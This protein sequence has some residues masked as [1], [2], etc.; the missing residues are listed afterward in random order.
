MVRQNA[1]V[2]NWIAN[3]VSLETPTYP[4]IIIME[5]IALILIVVSAFI[6]AG[7]NL[8]SKRQDPAAAFFLGTCMTGMLLLAPTIF[9]FH[10][11]II[12]C[13]TP[14][15]WL[16]LLATGFFMALYYTSLAGAYRAGDMSVAYPLARASPILV[17]LTVTWLLGRG[18]QLSHCCV[19][20]VLLV[21]GGCFLIPLQRFRDM[22]WRNYLTKT[23][24][25]ALLAAIGTAGYSILD[26]EALRILR[27]HPQNTLNAIQT[28]L[29]YLCFEALSASFW[30]ALFVAARPHRRAEA[31]L[32]LKTKK[33]RLVLTGLAIYLS[34]ALVLYALAF[35][36]NVSYVV[37]FRQ[38]SIPLGAIL[39]ITVLKE[40]PFTPKITGV[41]IMFAGL[42]L[43]A[44]A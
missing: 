23:C 27:D 8:A 22:R 35:A 16:F 10:D 4:H 12:H 25:L 26:D 2:L 21:V 32:L 6:H 38:L 41:L 39:G 42:I 20:G 5:I 24:G 14:R 37:G 31:R 17:V 18:G 19:V 13:F 43:I 28:S 29:L 30:I 40:A 11:T 44:L 36:R 9:F 34:Y 15:V 3:Y 33:L 7:W 1:G